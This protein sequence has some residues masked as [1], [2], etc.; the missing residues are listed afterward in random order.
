MTFFIRLGIIMYRSFSRTQ[1]TT[2]FSDLFILFW[3][4][5]WA[6]FLTLAPPSSTKKGLPSQ[7][8]SS[9]TNYDEYSKLLYYASISIRAIC[10]NVFTWNSLYSRALYG[11]T[12]GLHAFSFLCS[13]NYKQH[14]AS[15]L[16]ATENSY[17]LL[18]CHSAF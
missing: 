14:Q 4:H 7:K 12:F 17:F 16:A 11:Y 13:Y 1:S 2:Y 6:C 5:T 15:Y 10:I 18:F 9:T 3:G 8:F